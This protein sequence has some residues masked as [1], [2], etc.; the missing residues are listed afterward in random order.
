M[1][2]TLIGVDGDERE[3]DLR[4]GLFSGGV[5]H[6]SIVSDDAEPPHVVFEKSCGNELPRIFV[7]AEGPSWRR[8]VPVFVETQYTEI[9]TH[10]NSERRTHPLTETIKSPQ[11]WADINRKLDG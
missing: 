5:G 6:G 2:A 10:S 8:R 7:H 4:G 11:W 1:R 9:A 3:V